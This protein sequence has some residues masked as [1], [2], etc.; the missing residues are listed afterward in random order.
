MLILASSSPRRS[1]LLTRA[2]FD[3]K[4]VPST[5][6]E[7]TLKASGLPAEDLVM[8][9]ARGKALEVSARPLPKSIEIQTASANAEPKADGQEDEAPLVV[10]ADTV[11]ILDEKVLG[12][13]HTEEEAKRMLSALSGTTHR[14]LTGV[15]IAQDG[16]ALDVFCQSTQ[17]EFYPLDQAF[18]DA[19]VA[20]GEPMD[21]AGAYG[22][23]A[24]GSLLVKSITGDY[25]NVVGLPI[26]LL[27][28]H[29]EKYGVMPHLRQR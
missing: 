18:I 19:Y 20:G 24:E 12:K 29:L 8:G 21:K 4:T 3:F 7:A 11:V 14:V 13:P 2:G 6:D 9:L 23:Q 16:K 22:I 5:Y 10:G 1:E 25:F 27:A 15:C 28:R 17:V 26:A